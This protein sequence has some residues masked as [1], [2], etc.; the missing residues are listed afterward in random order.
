MLTRMKTED[1]GV[2]SDDDDNDFNVD[3]IFSSVDDDDNKATGV[4]Y[5]DDGYF[6][7]DDDSGVDDDDRDLCWL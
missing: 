5:D 4:K 1:P 2:D 7:V 6:C 3:N